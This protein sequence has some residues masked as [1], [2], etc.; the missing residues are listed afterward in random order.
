L[1]GFATILLAAGFLFSCSDDTCISHTGRSCDEGVVYWIDSCG[2]YQELIEECRCGCRADRSECKRCDDCTC[3]QVGICCDGCL[4]INENEF[5]DDGNPGTRLDLCREGTCVG[6]VFSVEEPALPAEPAA[7]EPVRLQSWTCPAGWIR[8][9]HVS[10]PDENDQPFSWCRPPPLPRL[11]AGEYITPLKDGESD[12]DRPVCEP[13]IDGTFPLL[14][15]ADCRP[16]GDPCPVGEWPVI[17]AEITGTRIHVREGAAGGDGTQAAPF[18]S[19]VEAVAAAAPGDVVVIAAGSYIE[20]VEIRKD[21]TLW[22]TCVQRCSVTAPHPG[23]GFNFGAVLVSGSASVTLRNLRIGGAQYGVRVTAPG[24]NVL[25]QGV[26]IHQ[27]TGQAVLATAG[28]VQLDRVLVDSTLTTP[29]GELGIGL[30]L[31]DG[32]DCRVLSATFEANR[33]VGVQVYTPQTVLRMQDVAIRNTQGSATS[34]DF[35]WGLQVKTGADAEVIRGLFDQNLQTGV[36]ATSANTRLLLEDAVIT[37][38]RC[39]TAGRYGDGLWVETGARGRLVRGLLSS[40]HHTGAI[41]IGA[42]ADLEIEDSVIQD[43]RVDEETGE[44]GLG[45]LADSGATLR[46]SRTVVE[47]NRP[48]G[49]LVQADSTSATLED[50][51]VRRTLFKEND[52]AGGWGLFAG[53]NSSVSVTRGLF[54]ENRDVAVYISGTG[55]QAVLEDVTAQDTECDESG[56]YGLG[57]LV[58]RG[59]QTSLTR[60]VFARNRSE[61]IR[62]TDENTWLQLTDVSISGTRGREKDNRLG[63]GLWVTEGAGAEVSRA[64]LEE[65]T[66]TGILVNEPGTSVS[67]EDITVRNTQ[68]SDADRTGGEGL[69]VSGGASVS[70]ARGWFEGNR[71]VGIYCGLA[72]S[73]LTI[74]DVTVIDTLCQESDGDKGFGMGVADG[75]R[76]VLQRGRFEGNHSTG[77]AAGYAGTSISLTDVIV[78]G[79]RSRQ[80]DL[81]LGRGMEVN[82]GAEATVQNGLFETNRDVGI[83]AFNPDT[84][85][86]LNQVTIRDTLERECASGAGPFPCEGFGHG[87]GLGVFY[88]A[89]VLLEGAEIESS[90]LA[91]LQLAAQGAATGLGLAV[92]ANRVGVN[93]QDVPDDYDFFEEVRA[94]IMEDNQINFDT[95]QLP[96]PDPLEMGP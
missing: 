45:I 14:G 92:S 33:M 44:F 3:I 42:G 86:T 13:E 17:P 57:L 59:A 82:M 74:E 65:N 63:S 54:E 28:T 69:W 31:R 11:K 9:E 73:E 90:Q 49:V 81:W 16:L 46:T 4:S 30:G 93:I 32:V 43:T 85:L 89:Q 47:R 61:G 71:Y 2:N 91:G 25:I 56:S 23:A 76:I 35:G 37:D 51:V 96:I 52:L 5:C 50:V 40:N 6:W 24:A 15:H 1:K 48:V 84:R 29:L 75:G 83:A 72:G 68:G 87:S 8:E 70:L 77:I 18:G 41:A 36:Y 66:Y 26:W 19:I 53:Q 95:T 22:G 20:V 34:A 60:G 55:T 94:L 12:G 79:T 39:D 38:T 88:G 80:S 62:A 10:L 78:R 7:A 21:L 27:A 64:L 67:L 58:D